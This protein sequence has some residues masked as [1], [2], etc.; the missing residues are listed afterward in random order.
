MKKKST[1]PDTVKSA[2]RV[3]DILEY[4]IVS[5]GPATL[6]ALSTELSLP[7][8]SCFALLRTLELNGY[9]Y[10]VTP[11]VGYYPTRRWFDRGRII[12]D[13]DPLLTKIKP[14]MTRLSEE[15]R[16][17]LIFGKRFGHQVMYIDVVEWPQTLRYTASAGQFKSLHCTAS[18]KAILSGM[19][20]AERS[21]LLDNYK[22]QKITPRTITQRAALEKELQVGIKRGWHISRG[23]NEPDTTAVAVPIVVA[24][25]VFMLAVGGITSRIEKKAEKIGSMLFKAVSQQQF[26]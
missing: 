15:T 12:A 13:N 2:Q 7:I 14:L 20:P 26:I 17:T 1:M 24:N 23:E 9:I 3:I 8:S 5:R 11:K 21:T 25:D 10:E 22:F 19:D 16:E 18:G 4:F 6:S